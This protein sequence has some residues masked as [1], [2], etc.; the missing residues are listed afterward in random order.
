MFALVE[1]GSITKL[2]NGNKGIE[3]NGVKHSAAIY[4][5]AWTEAERNNIGIYTVQID[6]TNF[7]DSYWYVNTDMTYSFG[8]GKV[9]GAYGT[10]TA[11]EADDTKWT[12]KQIDDGLA[13]V[14]ADTDTVAIK[15]LKTILIEQVKDQA[16]SELDRTD[17]YITRKTEKIQQYQVQFPHIGMP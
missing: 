12:Q 11:K 15:G 7:K 3:L 6:D 9:T 10:A 8:S 16:E 14:G 2:L 17:W 13:P 5:S 4:S 1:S